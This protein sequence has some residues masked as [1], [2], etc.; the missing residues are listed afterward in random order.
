MALC[1]TMASN[2]DNSSDFTNTGSRFTHRKPFILSDAAL[3]T[4]CLTTIFCRVSQY[5]LQMDGR[6]EFV[7]KAIT[8]GTDQF[9]S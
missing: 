1:L 8:D 9:G 3:F 2:N 7:F 5:Y 4:V 6:G